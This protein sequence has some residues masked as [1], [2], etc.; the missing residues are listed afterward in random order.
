MQYTKDDKKKLKH[1]K[2]LFKK[3]EILF[4]YSNILVL[5]TYRFT[6]SPSHLLITI[7]VR[8]SHWS[9]QTLTIGNS[10]SNYCIYPAII[11]E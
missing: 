9:Q 7:T 8:T 2:N 1:E 10:F 11:L 5:F 6:F 4:I 3:G